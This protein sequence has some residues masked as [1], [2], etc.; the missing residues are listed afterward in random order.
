MPLL[1]KLGPICTS[2]LSRD[3]GLGRFH[4]CARMFARHCPLMPPRQ[5]ARHVHPRRRHST[6]RRQAMTSW[7]PFSP[8][9]RS[10][11]IVDPGMVGGQE[12]CIGIRHRYRMIARNASDGTDAA[13][14]DKRRSAVNL[15]VAT[16]L[17]CYCLESFIVFL[18][19][20]ETL[21]F[22]RVNWRPFAEWLAR[23]F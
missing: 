5:S 13:R 7:P 6:I 9:F 8:T 19:V 21:G 20:S 16:C 23:F 1:T 2:Q 22:G 12:N 3:V 17:T 10:A 15:I 14:R 11:A 18:R 4:K